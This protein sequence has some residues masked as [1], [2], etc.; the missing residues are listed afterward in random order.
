MYEI[1]LEKYT[2]LSVTPTKMSVTVQNTMRSENQILYI[3]EH[4][5]N[6]KKWI[7]IEPGDSVKFGETMY[8]RQDAYDQWVFPAVEHD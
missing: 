5:D 8:L 6:T 4:G 2:P 7:K 3:S 1:I